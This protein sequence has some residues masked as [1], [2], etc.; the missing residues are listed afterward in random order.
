VVLGALSILVAV[1]SASA[2]T[3]PWTSDDILGV[4]A[5]SDPQVSPD[6]R[7]IVYVVQELNA[8][9]SEYQTDLWLIASAG[10]EARRLTRSTAIDENPRWSPDG[11]T[12]AFLSERE[13]PNKKKDADAAMGPAA[14]KDDEGKRQLWMI[15]PDGGEAWIASDSKG[16]VFD[17]A[18]S[19]DGK[20][21]AYLAHEPKSDERRKREKE[22]DD[23]HTPS[24]D[25][26][27]NRLWV[28]D[29][30]SGKAT[31]LTSGNVHVS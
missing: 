5:V 13:R 8:D 14:A 25:Y 28:M 1:Q 26:M 27:W 20:T 17:F 23:A 11:K 31:Q 16:G 19:R 29:V 22:K 24:E 30:A 2:T 21:I 12:I 18:W 15:R 9:G 6:G 4:K 10:G 3:R 7:W